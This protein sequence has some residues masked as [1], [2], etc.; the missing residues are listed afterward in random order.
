MRLIN[1]SLCKTEGDLSMWVGTSSEI[2]KPVP[3]S[4]I[5]AVVV[6]VGVKSLCKTDRDGK[7]LEPFVSSPSWSD[8]S[9]LTLPE[10]AAPELLVE[11]V[12]V[13]KIIP[14]VML[15][16]TKK[17]IGVNLVKIKAQKKEKGIVD[18]DSSIIE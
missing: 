7:R 8:G 11:K 10:T 13:K 15:R 12:E 3:K 14:M 16:K 6:V 5:S 2:W 18:I 1:L 17:I 9:S 4:R